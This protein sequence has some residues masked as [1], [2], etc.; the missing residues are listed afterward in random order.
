MIAVVLCYFATQ[1]LGDMMVV[2]LTGLTMPL[3]G[4]PICL[5]AALL[6]GLLSSLVPASLAARTTITDALR[7]AG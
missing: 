4:I 6:I 3:W 7:H 2:F 5:G 1:A